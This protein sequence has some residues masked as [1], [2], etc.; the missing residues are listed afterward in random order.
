MQFLPAARMLERPAPAWICY[1]SA[2][3][4]ATARMRPHGMEHTAQNRRVGSP[5]SN[6][7][8]G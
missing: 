3:A 5:F 2:G 4:L 1:R 8:V 6:I 7:T